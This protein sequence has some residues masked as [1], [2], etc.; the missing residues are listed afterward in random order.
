MNII[1][2]LSKLKGEEYLNRD[3]KIILCLLNEQFYSPSE[4]NS[5]TP[6]QIES[7]GLYGVRKI[8]ST[9]KD[10]VE[11][12]LV[13]NMKGN[14]Q[15]T[16]KFQYL[17]G[18]ISY[19]QMTEEDDVYDI[20]GY[21]QSKL[22]KFLDGLPIIN[23]YKDSLLKDLTIT[24]NQNKTIL[25]HFKLWFGDEESHKRFNEFHSSLENS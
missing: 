22:E 3:H 1:K 2:L 25:H 20:T 17:L 19:K 21:T 8:H 15:I 16:P 24:S 18:S 7:M 6:T 5:L 12:K 14:Y 13:D 4:K 23:S 11:W 9:L 10:L